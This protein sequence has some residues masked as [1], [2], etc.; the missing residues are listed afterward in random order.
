M[1]RANQA[2]VYC[3][4]RGSFIS[5]TF[6]VIN[7]EKKW[8]VI[9]VL[10]IARCCI[11]THKNQDSMEY[12]KDKGIALGMVRNKS[13]ANFIQPNEFPYMSG[14]IMVLYTDGITEA[15]DKKGEEFGYDRLSQIPVGGQNERSPPDSGT[16]DQ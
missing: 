9:R 1:K 7:T 4:E 14:D 10:V 13:Y 2:L 12:L 3:L 5:A 11:I 8:C 16:L 15:K 6:F